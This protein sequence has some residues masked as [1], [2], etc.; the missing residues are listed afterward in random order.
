ME[1]DTGA[2]VTIM[3][4]RTYRSLWPVDPPP[5]TQS[6]MSLKT[7]TGEK[8]QVLGCAWVRVVYKEQRVELPLLIVGG[9]GPSLLGRNWLTQLQLD[10]GSICTDKQDL[11]SLSSLLQ[12]YRRLF[13]EELGTL[14]GTWEKI[15]VSP[16]ALSRF[17]KPRPVPSGP[18][19]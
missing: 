10:W 6:S 16:D 5:L 19:G 12:K 17:H 15:H 9:R 14:I 4:E 2:S 7:Y 11:P 13:Q 3:S 18:Y 1:L 8:M